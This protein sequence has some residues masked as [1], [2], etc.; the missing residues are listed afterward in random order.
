MTMPRMR[1]ISASL[2]ESEDPNT[3][4]MPPIQAEVCSVLYTGV[5]AG[6]NVLDRW[7]ISGL[8]ESNPSSWLGKP[9]HYHY[10]KPARRDP[11]LTRTP[12]RRM[13]ATTSSRLASI[14][15]CV[16]ASRL[17]RRSGSVFD[18]RTLKCQ[19]GASTDTPSIR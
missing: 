17:R 4:R 11:I 19:S 15:A 13:K 5:R 3:H 16:V 10:A 12:Q 18:A 1:S 9:E 7:E 6:W 2:L 14:T 8:R